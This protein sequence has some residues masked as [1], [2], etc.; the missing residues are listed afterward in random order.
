MPIHQVALRVSKC[1]RLVSLKTT[2][3]PLIEDYGLISVRPSPI[4]LIACR[5]TGLETPGDGSRASNAVFDAE[6]VFIPLHSLHSLQSRHPPPHPPQRET[7]RGPEIAPIDIHRQSQN[8]EPDLH[9][10]TRIPPR[11]LR[12]HPEG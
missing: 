8:V 3:S 12:G 2:P 5:G 9:L 10:P 11:C 1:L 7:P 4:G 6:I